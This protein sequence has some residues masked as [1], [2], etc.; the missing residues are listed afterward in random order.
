M[1]GLLQAPHRSNSHRLRVRC[2]RGAVLW[3]GGQPHQ[4]AR[5]GAIRDQDHAS[6]AGQRMVRFEQTAV[7][8]GQSR[9]A[10]RT[11]GRKPP[12]NRSAI[13]IEGPRS[14]PVII[15]KALGA[16]PAI[17]RELKAHKAAWRYFAGLSPFHRL[18]YIVWIG[19]AKRDDTR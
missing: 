10:P 13:P 14:V 19:M 16:R 18:R 11:C 4:T 5:R 7:R 17:E 12:S 3:L 2:R 6:E 1:A 9:R 8:E 15:R